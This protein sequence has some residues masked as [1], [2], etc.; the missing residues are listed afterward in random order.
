MTLGDVRSTTRGA[1]CGKR[2]CPK[3]ID[4]DRVDGCT[5]ASRGLD[6][7]HRA[8]GLLRRFP[9]SIESVRS[10]EY[11]MADPQSSSDTLELVIRFGTWVHRTR[12]GAQALVLGRAPECDIHLPDGNVSR[13]HC[14]VVPV[15]D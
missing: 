15:G 2:P 12:L 10:R 7:R 1:S 11:V 3:R 13:K 5:A 8:T 6:T 14:R 9:S 4:S